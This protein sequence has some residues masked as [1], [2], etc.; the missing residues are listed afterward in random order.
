MNLTINDIQDFC[1]CPRYYLLKKNDTNEYT[2]NQA[3]DRAVHRCIY[4][5]L[6]MFQNDAKQI[7][8]DVLKRAWGREWIKQKTNSEMI[9]TPSAGKRDTYDIKRKNGIN[10]IFAFDEMMQEPQFPIIINKPYSI[11]I[12]NVVVNGVWEYIR[13]ITRDGQKAFQ[14]IRF[15]TESNR[16]D[17]KEQMNHDIALTAAYLAFKATFNQDNT[18]LI[19]MD[20]YRKTMVPA[21]R[22]K[23]DITL[24]KETVRS[25]ALS[26]KN[27]LQCVS[28]DKK[29]FHCEYR[30]IC[31][32]KLG[33]HFI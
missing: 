2:I 18:E 27:N 17:L 31:L 7:S 30:D 11:K 15:R 23:N 25:V 28:P 10:A 1:F 12:G 29:C 9:C 16:F 19:Y 14:I 32:G 26:I 8:I 5:Y 24:F 6:Y 21:F 33:G 20:L 3:Y 4:E 13:E 22:T